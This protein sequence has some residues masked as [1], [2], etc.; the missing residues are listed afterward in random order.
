MNN[1]T[2]FEWIFI[3]ENDEL[4]EGPLPYFDYSSGP[5]GDSSKRLPYY[6]YGGEE[7][8]GGGEPVEPSVD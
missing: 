7:G 4:D 8:G 6:D 3:L 1:M 2:L 5:S